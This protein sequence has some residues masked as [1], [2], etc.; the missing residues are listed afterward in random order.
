MGQP[1]RQ[2]VAATTGEQASELPSCVNPG[3]ENLAL[4]SVRQDGWLATE[5]KIG[6]LRRRKERQHRLLRSALCASLCSSSH[7]HS[8]SRTVDV[9]DKIHRFKMYRLN[10]HSP[11]SSHR[12]QRP[13]RGITSPAFTA[14]PS[15]VAYIHYAFSR[16]LHIIA[17]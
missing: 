2:A 5:H 16:P 7:S 4:P 13:P 10:I 3:P 12:F 17:K 6:F 8:S 1:C 15:V 11:S 14:P 9:V